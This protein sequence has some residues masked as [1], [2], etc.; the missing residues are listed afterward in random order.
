MATITENG[1]SDRLTIYMNELGYELNRATMVSTNDKIN[2][3]NMHITE[4]Q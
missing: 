1:W 2:K 4:S 3:S